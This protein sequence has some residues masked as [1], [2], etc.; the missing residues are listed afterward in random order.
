MFPSPQVA[1]QKPLYNLAFIIILGQIGP[2][3][4]PAEPGLE[5]VWEAIWH[6]LRGP[7]LMEMMETPYKTW[8]FFKIM[9]KR[10]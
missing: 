5:A 4:S 3:P 6:A 9:P 8:C 10:G 2:L 1:M 7:K